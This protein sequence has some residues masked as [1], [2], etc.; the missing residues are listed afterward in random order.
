MPEE[1]TVKS[2]ETE[3][4]LVLVVNEEIVSAY[5]LLENIKKKIKKNI[6]SYFF[7]VN[8]LKVFS[9]ATSEGTYFPSAR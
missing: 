9:P 5:K 2:S 6:F 1:V 4:V 8:Y 7:V 3:V